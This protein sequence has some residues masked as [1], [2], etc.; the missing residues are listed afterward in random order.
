[1]PFPRTS[2]AGMLAAALMSLPV[3][4]VQ[5]ADIADTSGSDDSARLAASAKSAESSGFPESFISRVSLDHQHSLRTEFWSGDRLLSDQGSLLQASIWSQLKVDAGDA[6]QILAKGWLRQQSSQHVS[7]PA[8]ARG[9][10]REL[11]WRFQAGDIQLRLGRQLLAWGRAD[12]VNP[13]DNLSPRD[14]RLLTPEDSDQRTGSN[15][16]Q[17][18]FN[19]SAG[20]FSL[21]AMPA[22][23]SHRLPLPQ[24]TG[25]QLVQAEAEHQRAFAL[26]WD[27]SGEGLDASLSVVRGPDLMPG[28]NRVSMTAQGLQLLLRPAQATV[29]GADLSATAGGLIWRAEAAYSRYTDSVSA[30]SVAM[31]QPKRDQWMLVAGP[32]AELGGSTTLGVQLLMQQVRDWRDPADLPDT[33]LQR[34]AMQQAAFQNQTRASQTGFTWRLATRKLNDSLLAEVSGVMLAPQRA[35]LWRAKVDYA[36]NDRWHLQGGAERYFG[37]RSHFFGQLKDN[38][39]FYLQ[40]RAGF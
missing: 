23:N 31:L 18:I 15:A 19:S 22:L 3:L 36:L 24:V 25:I 10:L 40:L 21:T 26:K 9:A 27:Y 6:G 2:M 34:L 8:P 5:A 13:T 11:Y 29:F 33:L 28:L 35:G 16:L 17:L 20:Q 1:M 32:E 4:P 7:V 38:Q 37:P 39:P 12:G 14:F 30:D